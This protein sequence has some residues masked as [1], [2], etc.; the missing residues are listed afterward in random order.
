MLDVELTLVRTQLGQRAV[1]D[2]FQLGQIELRLLRL[3]NGYTPL[4]DLI[5][6]LDGRLDWHSVAYDLLDQGF[7]IEAP[8]VEREL[9][10]VAAGQPAEQ[11]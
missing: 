4:G 5:A 3:V 8:E 10:A 7:V 2:E 9:P 6:R 11:R 1:F